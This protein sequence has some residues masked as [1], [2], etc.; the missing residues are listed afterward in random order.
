[1]DNF[2]KIRKEGRLLYEYIRGSQSYGLALPTSDIDTG[3]VFVM[4][5]ETLYG[6]PQYKHDQVDDE[7]HDTTWYEIGRYL[8]LLLKSNPTMLES[9][10]VPERCI[11]YVHP[12]FK[13]ILENRDIFVTKKCFSGFTSYA[14]SQIAKA[15]GLNKKINNP[16]T[17]RK[18][19]LDFCWTFNNEQGTMHLSK[20]LEKRGLLQKY[21]GLNHMPNMEEMYGV[22]YDWEE[23]LHLT[24]G[25]PEALQ[26]A[27]LSIYSYTEEKISEHESAL[28]KHFYKNMPEESAKIRDTFEEWLGL[29]GADEEKAKKFLFD[30]AQSLYENTVPKGYHGIMRED[31]TS[32]DI[33]LDSIA[34]GDKPICTMH[35]NRNG[36]QM[37]CREYREYKEWE[38]KRN[39]QRF[40]EN[41]DKDFDRKNIAHCV[42]LIT[43]GIEIAKTGKVNVD[44]TNIDRDFILNIRLGNTS[45][46]E[47]MEYVEGKKQELDEAIKNCSLPEDVDPEKV[48]ELLIKIRQEFK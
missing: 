12:A 35:F 1:M 45:Y 4:S 40:L 29:G 42:R 46:E 38:Q 47:I 37:H 30:L 32:T 44:R 13:V 2:E 10:F 24:F 23:D 15:K 41:K 34:V 22:F 28:I 5:P 7:R 14:I 19:P 9:L 31:G 33:R 17:E 43:M 20:W 48:N 26:K 21:C 6:L 18:T 39:P 11:K 8:E 3:G 25:S 27:L 36:Y 16:M